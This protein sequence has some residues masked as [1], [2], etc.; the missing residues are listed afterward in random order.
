MR[1]NPCWGIL[2]GRQ[3]NHRVVIVRNPAVHLQQ[4]PGM[5]AWI[6]A[7]ENGLK[8]KIAQ[9]VL[10]NNPNP[11]QDSQSIRPANF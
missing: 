11:L 2:I 9:Q 10:E 6:K 5:E 3:E 7:D 8:G 4:G 1:R